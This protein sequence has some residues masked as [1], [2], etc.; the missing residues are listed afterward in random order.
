MVRERSNSF[1]LLTCACLSL[2]LGGCSDDGGGASTET[3]GSTGSA[4]T[5][6]GTS[7]TDPGTST[8][9]VDPTTDTTEESTTGTSSTTDPVTSTGPAPFCGDGN[10]DDGEECDAGADNGD[11][12]ACTSACKTGVCGDGLVI[13]GAEECDAGVD[14]GDDKACTAACKINVCGDGLVHAGV[15]A[16]DDGNVAADDGCSAT[17]TSESCGDG[18]T[19][20]S[21]ECDDANAD[22]TDACLATC[23]AAKCGDAIVWANM[24]ACDDG[25]A[26]ET[27]MCTTLCKAPA[28]DD[29]IKSGAET[30][31]DCGGPACSKCAL[32]KACLAN[33]D[34]QSGVCKMNLCA[35]PPKSCKEVLAND[36]AAKS[37]L[38]QVDL[39]GNA[40]TPAV[41]VYCDMTTDGGGWTIVYAATGADNQVPVTSNTEVLMGNPLMF[42]YYNLSRNK[43]V[44]LGAL[45][46]ETLFVRN[47][48]TWLKANAAA[49]N[50]KLTMNNQTHKVPVSLAAN[51]GVQAM[52]FMGFATFSTQGGGDFGVTQAPD[53]ATCGGMTMTGF[54][55]HGVNFRM[56]NCGCARHYIY[57]HSATVNDGDAGYDSF[58]ALGSWGASQANCAAATAEGGALTFY[59]AMR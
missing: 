4:T 38:F 47:N 24:E 46:G 7:T 28:C 56:L 51:N 20:A 54:D 42:Q 52:G 27:D 32:D 30:D 31:V 34:C 16:C 40:N 14:N 57:S 44:L 1:G 45:S 37:G 25:N 13:A 17:C 55:H 36:P 10:V 48:N 39:D 6:V 35:P 43:K 15:E 50:D 19:Q 49:F 29:T 9:P 59:M 18:V 22:D 21:E 3:T 11:D 41:D 2:L 5:A 58:V 26:D 8:G 12:K 23:I 33:A 53:A